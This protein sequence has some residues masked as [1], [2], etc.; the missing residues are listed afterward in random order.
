ME[1]ENIF[2]GINKIQINVSLKNVFIKKTMTIIS[3]LFIIN[4]NVFLFN[5]FYMSIFFFLL[6]P[7]FS[8]IGTLIMFNLQ[9]YVKKLS[10]F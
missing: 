7:I 3:N 10:N 8:L 5:F 6:L 2:Y 1:L 9:F 4:G